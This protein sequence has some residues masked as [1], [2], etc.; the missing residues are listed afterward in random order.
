MANFSFSSSKV[1]PAWGEMDNLHQHFAQHAF[2][3]EQM[4]KGKYVIEHVEHRTVLYPVM[5]MLSTASISR[6]C[7]TQ[8]FDNPAGGDLNQNTTKLVL[9][10]LSITPDSQS[11]PRD[12][13]S[14]ASDHV[15]MPHPTNE[16][17][18]AISCSLLSS[19]LQGRRHHLSNLSYQQ[20]RNREAVTSL[21]L[22]YVKVCHSGSIWLLP[23]N[24]DNY[25]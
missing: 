21:S 17:L 18:I 12:E 23:K 5:Y 20:G 1:W 24:A 4:P 3:R 14:S 16:L 9:R 2:I 15:W 25:H 11:K 8:D 7:L 22:S 6:W 19:T 13:N 10:P